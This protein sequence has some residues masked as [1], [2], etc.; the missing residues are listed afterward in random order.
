MVR[1]YQKTLSASEKHSLRRSFGIDDKAKIILSV[2]RLSKEKNI[3]ELI[4]FLP[5]I[6][7]KMPDVKLLLVGGGP[8]KRH[9]EKQAE[10]LKLKNSIIFAGCVP[11]D[12]VWRY[13]S[14]GDIFASASTFEV[15]SMSY[16]E[17]LAQG[18]PLLCRA[19][20]ALTGVLE[21]NYNGMIYRSQEEFSDYAYR[22]LSDDK[23][24][25]SMGQK[26]QKKAES[27]SSD[28]FA[29]SVIRLYKDA[30]EEKVRRCL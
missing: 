11:A 28:A 13:Y 22:I 10:K 15:H 19:D 16:L 18:L 17:A 1:K 12:D 21:H 9:L 23:L 27:F 30:V 2:S 6:L 14:I 3:R 7:E 24:R 4:A 26:S 29:A 25:K 8:D 5:S 20:D